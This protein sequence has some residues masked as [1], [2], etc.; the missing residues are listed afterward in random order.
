LILEDVHVP[1][2]HE[3]VLLDDDV[4]HDVRAT[5]AAPPASPDEAHGAPP[6]DDRLTEA[7]RHPAD[8]RECADA[9]AHGRA[10][11]RHQS[12]RIYGGHDHGAGCPAP[13]VVDVHPA[14]IV[15]WC[16]A[17][18]RVIDPRPAVV[19]IPDPPSRRVRGPVGRHV[20][21]DPDVA[22]AWRVVPVART[23]EVA[24]AGDLGRYVL[25]ATRRLVRAP[26][27]IEVPAVPF[28]R[29]GGGAGGDLRC[30][31]A[32]EDGLLV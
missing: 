5:P 32:L 9:H 3:D 14:T 15:I 17:P 10:D 29:I 24:T 6:R 25:R 7:E 2:V 1:H 20:A 31:L 22:V 8:E 19:R 16:P 21:G 30:V 18:G 11:E 27:A 4:V 28:I 26:A 12:R 23:V 13:V